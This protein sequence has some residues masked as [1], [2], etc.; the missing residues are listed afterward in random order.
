MSQEMNLSE[1]ESRALE[2][3]DQLSAAPEATRGLPNIGDLCQK[4]QSLKPTLQILVRV[5]RRIPGIGGRAASALE[6]L[7]SIA[8][9]ACAIA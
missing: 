5:L 3:L 6:F 2:Q 8:D 7:M 4:Y 9:T 1:E